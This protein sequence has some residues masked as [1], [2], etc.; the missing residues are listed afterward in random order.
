MVCIWL[1]LQMFWPP[2]QPWEGCS[3]WRHAPFRFGKD[4]SLHVK[5]LPDLEV[6]QLVRV[7][8][9]NIFLY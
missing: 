8:C 7:F 3:E 5:P 4:L 9:F 6:Q 2:P 1:A